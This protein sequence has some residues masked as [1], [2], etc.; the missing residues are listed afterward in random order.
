MELTAP[1]LVRWKSATRLVAS[2]YPVAGLLD[3]VASP[4]DLES[5]FELEGWTNDRISGELGLLRTIPRHEW[6]IGQPMASVVMAAY[7]HPR[8][9]GGRFSTGERGAWYAART[10]DTAFAES[11]YHRTNELREVGAFDTFVQMRVYLADFNARLIDV[12]ERY[13]DRELY[14]PD[15]YTKSQ[16][17]GQHG[18]DAGGKGIVFRSVRDPA[19][20]CLACFRPALVRN[21]RAGGHYELR[22]HGRPEPSVRRL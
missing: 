18:L 22:W 3:R 16:Q 12:R 17:F 2:R 8:T 1:I 9:G 10:I 7:C 21:V 11:I 15:S 14:D 13:P 5:L 4:E 20:E 19:G 6:V